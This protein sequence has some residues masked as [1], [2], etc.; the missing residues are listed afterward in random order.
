MKWSDRHNIILFILERLNTMN[1][2]SMLKM[3][4]HPFQRTINNCH[5]VICSDYKLV[6]GCKGVKRPAT[7]N[8]KGTYR[9]TKYNNKMSD[10]KL[11]I[12]KMLG[13]IGSVNLQI[14]QGTYDIVVVTSVNLYLYDK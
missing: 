6:Q 11:T 3:Q 7:R 10:N 8:K 13:L 2:H 4:E 12:T 5:F 1:L 14:R 9:I